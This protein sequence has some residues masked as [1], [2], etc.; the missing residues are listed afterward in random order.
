LVVLVE[1][2]KFHVGLLYRVN[3]FLV[4]VPPLRER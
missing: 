1:E 2:G 4:R 3:V